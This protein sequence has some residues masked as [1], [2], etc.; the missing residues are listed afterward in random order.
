MEAA[1]QTAVTGGECEAWWVFSGVLTVA[2]K[3][4]KFPASPCMTSQRTFGFCH[5]LV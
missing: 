2:T 3:Q 4:G 5:L 1:L